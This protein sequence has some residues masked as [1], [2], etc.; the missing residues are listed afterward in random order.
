M[1]TESKNNICI[2]KEG[3]IILV[4][5]LAYITR[6]LFYIKYPVPWRDS[7]FYYSVMAEYINQGFYP[8]TNLWG[9]LNYLPPVPSFLVYITHLINN[10][11]IVNEAISVEIC[12]GL[13]LVYCI[14]K[15]VLTAFG[16]RS[17]ALIVSLI[18]AVH[19][20][21]VEISTQFSRDNFYLA[22]ISAMLLSI[23]SN[24][25]NRNILKNLFIGLFL[26]LAILCRYESFEFFLVY[27]FVFLIF[28]K[29]I[30]QCMLHSI[31]FYFFTALFSAIMIQII[32]CSS[33]YYY[34]AFQRIFLYL[35]KL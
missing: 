34:S 16:S 7:M 26:S 22:F 5:L 21:L 24:I 8:E 32:G 35:S 10:G 1:K 28:V 13:V 3:D 27:P 15:T 30:K 4:L 14:W 19:P 17:I 18:A 2:R 31:A 20:L 25:K 12:F 11:S 9:S 23:V 6:I 33:F 29:S